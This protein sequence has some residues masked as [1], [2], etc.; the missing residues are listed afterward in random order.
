MIVSTHFFEVFSM[1]LIPL[2]HPNLQVLTMDVMV[3]AKDGCEEVTFLYRLK[4]GYCTHSYG[5][6][7]AKIAGEFTLNSFYRLNLPRTNIF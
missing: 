1:N 6:Y 4:E 2:D 3:S 7:V 5:Q